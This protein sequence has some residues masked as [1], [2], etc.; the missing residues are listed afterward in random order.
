MD[1]LNYG[2][3]LIFTH[4]GRLFRILSNEEYFS[5]HLN[6]L[7]NYLEIDSFIE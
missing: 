7:L 3:L 1:I 5:A 2:I 6:V 4:F